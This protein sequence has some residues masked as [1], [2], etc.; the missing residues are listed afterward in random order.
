MKNFIRQITLMMGLIFF[1]FPTIITAQ[2][3]DLSVP[4]NWAKDTLLSDK[5]YETIDTTYTFQQDENKNK[6]FI[7]G[8]T[9]DYLNRKENS[10]L[11]L[12][13]QWNSTDSNWVNKE[14]TVKSY[15]KHDK[16]I[17]SLYQE[18]N[19]DFDDWIHVK[20]KTIT[21]EGREKSEV[22]YQEWMKPAGEWI[23]SMLYMLEYNRDGEKSDIIIK[24]Y[25]PSNDTWVNAHR[26]DFEYQ[27]GYGYPDVVYLEKW[28][29]SKKSW[30]KRGKYN[31]N[32]NIR[33]KKTFESRATWNDI[34]NEWINSI[35]YMM[36]YEKDKITEEIEQRYNYKTKEWVNANRS[37]Y[38]YNEAGELKTES[39]QKWDSTQDDWKTVNKFMYSDMRE[40]VPEA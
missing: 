30:A 5:D 7:Y 32:H 31:L 2:Q 40:W 14:R 24:T 26:Y 19:T 33:G 13:Q 16:E 15:N 4:E 17:Q 20:M 10:V 25:A 22:L 27:S 28:I 8:R 23:N 35:R 9:L 18:W 39:R 36:E 6:W 21:Y 29:P 1:L 11:L 12:N 37:L 38:E 34:K 3:A